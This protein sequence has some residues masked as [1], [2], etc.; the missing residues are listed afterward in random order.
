MAASR[1]S[2][3]TDSTIVSQRRDSKRDFTATQILSRDKVKG[4]RAGDSS[5]MLGGEKIRRS[6]LGVSVKFAI[7]ISGAIA[8]F[9]LLFGLV[10]FTNVKKALIDEIDAAGVQA[11]RAMA[12]P[13]FF[14]W[15]V[16]HGA[17][18]GT[19]WGGIEEDISRGE[20]KIPRGGLS[21]AQQSAAKSRMDFNRKRLERLLTQD[22][23]ILDAVITDPART[24]IVASARGRS[25]DFAGGGAGVLQN[26]KIEVGTYTTPEGQALAARQFVAPIHNQ[27]GGVV[28]QATVVLSEKAIQ[29]KLGKVR[30]QVLLLALVFVG[31]GVGVAFVMGSRITMPIT[32]LTRDVE[33]ISKGRLDHHP[34]IYT[35]DEIGVLAKTV[36][37]M[38][39]SL[40]AAQEQH[41]HHEKQKHQLQIALE[42]QNSLFPK[43][44]PSVQGYEVESHY[45]PGPE[46]GGD[47]YDVF[48]LPD[49]RLLMMVASASGRGIPAAMLTTMARSFTTAL[50][51]RESSTSTML[52]SVN[53][54]LSPD[55]RRGMYVTALVVVLDPASGKLV[56]VNAGH[57]PLILYSAEKKACAPVHC[58]GIALGFDKGPV[59]DRSLQE[60]EMQ[61]TKGDRI[62]LCTPGVFSTRNSSD[63]ELGEKGF[64][65]LVAREGAKNSTAFVNLVAHTLE[66]FTDGGSIES[67]ITFVTLKRL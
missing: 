35:K 49:G 36:D 39:K 41:S 60:L 50:A 21:E 14:T 58:D 64:Y 12:M 52:K 5:V 65:Q 62:V 15:N 3:R 4:K 59:F 44:L 23:R 7:A 25:V 45:H 18:T 29:D 61:L 37:R 17:Y 33:I 10:I 66:K 57:T 9:M 30:M 38:A 31:L 46:V 8:A 22:G 32:E 34:K 24:N 13:D 11:A 53:R 56:V 27:D 54:L 19:E 48:T 47:Y 43:S 26:V 2:R 42:I 20:K 6:G 40:S 55:L 51:E 1:K 67:D 28:G 63:Q 16:F